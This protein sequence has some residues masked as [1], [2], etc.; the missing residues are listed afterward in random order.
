MSSYFVARSEKRE[1]EPEG[2]QT[3][4]GNPQNTQVYET[5]FTEREGGGV[6]ERDDSWLLK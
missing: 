3:R 6:T 2:R 1:I 4:Q 5:R